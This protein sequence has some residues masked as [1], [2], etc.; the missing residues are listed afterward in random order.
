MATLAAL[1]FKLHTGWA[2]LVAAVGTRAKIEVLLRRRIELL[3]SGD[4]IPRFV[5][6]HAAE[7]SLTQATKAVQQAEVAAGAATRAALSD[8]VDHLRSLGVRVKAAGVASAS[9]PMPADLAL[10]LRSHPMIHAAEAALFRRAIIAAC[11]DRLLAVSSVREREI[12]AKTAEAW[13]FREAVLRKR[14]EDLRKS[15]GAP[16][17]SDQ[18]T[19]T[20]YALLAL[21]SHHEFNDH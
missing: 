18:K 16:W 17:G 21:R 3:P 1:G 11:E 4:L 5:Y 2:V 8:V 12:W 19:A 9:K 6:H 13:G 7:L 14:I 15:V 10:V 20:A